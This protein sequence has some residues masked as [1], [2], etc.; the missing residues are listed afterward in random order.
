MAWRKGSDRVYVCMTSRGLSPRTAE[1]TLRSMRPV[2]KAGTGREPVTPGCGGGTTAARGRS[3]GAHWPQPPHFRDRDLGLWSRPR[4]PD[5]LVGR[6]LSSRTAEGTAA[7][8]RLWG[9]CR[10]RPR[11]WVGAGP[12]R[13]GRA[14]RTLMPTH[15][16]RRV[17]NHSSLGCVW[18]SRGAAS[19]REKHTHEPTFHTHMHMHTH[20]PTFPTPF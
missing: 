6:A 13:R 8:G 7:Q 16:A 12:P 9:T 19:R 11:T 4:P 17:P 15:I 3:T 2:Y 10:P 5:P 18:S 1:G 14:R 20:E